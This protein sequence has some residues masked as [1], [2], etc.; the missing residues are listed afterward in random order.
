[1]LYKSSEAEAF[2]VIL[3]VSFIKTDRS[4]ACMSPPHP[5]TVICP[6]SFPEA[7][8]GLLNL[9]RDRRVARSA[10]ESGRYSGTCRV[11]LE[12][13]LFFGFVF[14][15]VECFQLVHHTHSS[16]ALLHMFSFYFSS[17]LRPCRTDCSVVQFFS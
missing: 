8:C 9:C 15:F 17:I 13:S 5:P 4:S 2:S 10:L 3:W 6:C 12:Q 14:F 1:M 11:R 7:K 16:P